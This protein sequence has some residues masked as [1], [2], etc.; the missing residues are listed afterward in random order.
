MSQNYIAN[1]VTEQTQFNALI[2]SAENPNI[3]MFQGSSGS[4]KS[5][6]LNHCLGTLTDT[7][8]KVAKLSL[9]EG[10]GSILNLFKA[11]GAEMGWHNLPHFNERVAGLTGKEVDE[12]ETVWRVKMRSHLR[13]INRISDLDTRKDWYKQLAEAWF[14]DL[15][16]Y[17]R[18][19]LLSID[20]YEKREDEFDSWFSNEFLFGVADTDKLRVLIGG[21]TVPEPTA[22]WGFCANIHN[23][24]G[25]Q[26]ANEWMA[27][28]ERVKIAIPSLEW[29]AGI[30]YGLKG[31]PAEIIRT[32]ETLPRI[33][34]NQTNDTQSIY[35]RRKKFR[36]T[37]G[38]LF[39]LSELYNICSDMQVD[40]EDL[41]KHGQK[42]DLVRELIAHLTRRGRIEE[43][44][45]ICQEE[46][47]NADWK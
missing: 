20:T 7:D 25:I 3:L 32:L 12:D 4:G 5:H 15:E 47:P 28:G 11:F 36:E 22:E 19:L 34:G 24:Q 16:S 42:S 37:A 41:P 27:W 17:N 29:L 44:M 45:T 39:S 46:R 1:F 9:L 33:V 35:A 21:Q 13:E 26:D 38:E 18:P 14:I 43:F 6:L 30:C 31:H 23:L 8:W 40:Y 2:D 10:G